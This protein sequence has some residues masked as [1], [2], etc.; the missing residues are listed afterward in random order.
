LVSLEV[1]DGLGRVLQSTVQANS[2][3]AWQI[4]FTE[5]QM[6]NLQDGFLTVRAQAVDR[7]G[8]ISLIKLPVQTISLHRTLP[9]A[10]QVLTLDPASD[11]GSGFDLTTLSDRIFNVSRPVLNGTAGAN[12][13]VVLWIDTNG[14]GLINGAESL[15][16]V[17]VETD[18]AGFFSAQ[19]PALTVKATYT[20]SA[21]TLDKWGNVS[22]WGAAQ[23]DPSKVKKLTLTYDPLAE[24]LQLDTIALDDRIN[25]L[26]LNTNGVNL[27][28]FAEPS[29]VIQVEVRQNGV[30]LQTYE[31]TANS[32][33]AWSLTNFG[34][35]IGLTD[36]LL[37]ISVKQTD[38]AG[39]T[40]TVSRLGIPVRVTPLLPVFNVVMDTASNSNL[41][42]DN[43]TNVVRPFI[44]GQGQ[45]G[46]GLEVVIF[47]AGLEIGRTNLV[48]GLFNW[49]SATPLSQGIHNLVFKVQDAATGSVSAQELSLIC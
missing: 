30:L 33:R 25:D 46:N 28:G 22:N 18:Q 1:V 42:T 31:T 13:R 32:N 21:I 2:T 8:N 47:E 5:S 19:V 7:A 35:N 44:T 24:G 40:Q 36:G 26:E 3:G 11:T 15:T 29:A 41:L 14:D 43:I 49:Q 23:T 6:L 27:T 48:N 4:S 37:N 20:Y 38:I 10:A 16:Q 39:N 17:I 12:Q 9:A 34:Q 45:Q